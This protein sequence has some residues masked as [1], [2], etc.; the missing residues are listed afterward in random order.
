LGITS[1]P[2]ISGD[3]V[4][5]G[6]KAGT[7]HALDIRTG[8]VIWKT[9]VGE[10]ITAPPVVSGSVIWLQAE[11]TF[12]LNVPDGKV[13]WRAGMGNSLHSAPVVTKQAVYLAGTG[14]EVYALE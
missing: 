10:V 2:A 8:K 7:L 4:I 9:Q 13:I 6:C 12:A 11:I 1:A 14:G 5:F 3:L